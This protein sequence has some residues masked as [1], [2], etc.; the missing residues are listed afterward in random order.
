MS[1]L[2]VNNNPITFLLKTISEESPK[3][4]EYVS[5]LRQTTTEEVKTISLEKIST[6]DNYQ[7]VNVSTK[8][9]SVNAPDTVSDLSYQD[10][11]QTGSV[12]DGACGIIS[13]I[14]TLKQGESYNL[15]S[16]T[17]RE[18]RSNKYLNMPRSGA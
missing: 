15:T 7:K 2:T 18:F 14:N 10:A 6:L 12:R 1:S 8:V 11:D 4:L 17:V 13:Y 3:K 9:I 16:F 5:T